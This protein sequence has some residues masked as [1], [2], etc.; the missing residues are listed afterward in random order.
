M[1]DEVL[2]MQLVYKGKANSSL[3]AIEFPA[4]S[5]LIYSKKTLEQR[6]GNTKSDPKH[7]LSIHQS[8]AKT[9]AKQKSYG[10]IKKSR[11]NKK[12]TAK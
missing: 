8:K 3:P 12:A 7:H 11:Q 9:M 1:S 6:K 4:D 10:K 5:L 2:P